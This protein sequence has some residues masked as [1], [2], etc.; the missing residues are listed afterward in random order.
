MNKI[1]NF[2]QFCVC[3]NAISSEVF[4]AGLIDLGMLRFCKFGESSLGVSISWGRCKLWWWVLRLLVRMIEGH[5]LRSLKY[6]G[7][8]A[9][10]NWRGSMLQ[11]TSCCKFC[12]ERNV[13]LKYDMMAERGAELEAI[14]IACSCYRWSINAPIL[15]HLL[16]RDMQEMDLGLSRATTCQVSNS[17]DL[18]FFRSRLLMGSIN[19]WDPVLRPFFFPCFLYSLFFSPSKTHPR[20]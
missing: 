18:F 17:G 7:M 20:G 14:W 11:V 9:V 13:N 6:K 5:V 16:L 19:S 8:S 15:R 12:G 1:L 10:L 3:S 4:D 2:C